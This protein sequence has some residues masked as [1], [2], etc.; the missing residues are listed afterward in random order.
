MDTL[1]RFADLV[2]DTVWAQARP[3][4]ATVVDGIVDGVL[5]GQGWGATFLGPIA[6]LLG[7]IGMLVTAV[8]LFMRSTMLYFVAAFAPLVWSSSVLPMMR[9]GVRKLVHTTVALVLAKPAI[10]ITLSIG[11]RLVAASPLAGADS[12]SDVAQVGTLLTGFFAFGVAALS[13]WVV[14]KLLPSAEGA[15]MHSGVA[16]GWA[17]SGMSVANGAMMARSIGKSGGA[18]SKPVPDGTDRA[19][20]SE[21]AG[22]TGF[23]APTSTTNPKPIAPTTE[24]HDDGRHCGRRPVRLLRLSPGRRWSPRRPSRRRPP[25]RRRPP[26]PANR[27][28]AAPRPTA[29]RARRSPSGGPRRV[30]IPSKSGKPEGGVVSDTSRD[31][32]DVLVRRLGPPGRAA[33]VPAA[34]GD[35]G[36]CRGDGRRVRVDGRLGPAGDHRPGRRA[37]GRVRPVAGRAAVRDRGAVARAAG[38]AWAQDVDRRVAR[39]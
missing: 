33:R 23:G 12:G 4:I 29:V 13:P 19:G 2:S 20:N 8:L 11:M 35:A 21:Q 7:M 25:L 14:Y 1:I 30:V 18:A 36:R 17:R 22:S 10:V 27:R 34:A 3:D 26:R 5:K 28:V 31:S 9:G 32:G 37:G 15:A 16:G 38:G 6:L 39:R 24:H